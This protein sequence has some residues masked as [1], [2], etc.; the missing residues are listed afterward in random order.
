MM[1]CADL[2]HDGKFVECL[3]FTHNEIFSD[4]ETVMGG[5]VEALTM[6]EETGK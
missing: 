4:L 6:F 3:K 1:R 5:V 2:V